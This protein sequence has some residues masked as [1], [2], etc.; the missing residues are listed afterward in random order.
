[1][2]AGP[3]LVS[4]D[5]SLELDSTYSPPA[6]IPSDP[7]LMYY[8]S[9]EMDHMLEPIKVRVV[10]DN[11]DLVT[12]PVTVI[13][14][15]ILST[16]WDQPDNSGDSYT[17]T[18]CQHTKWSSRFGTCRF[19][20]DDCIEMTCN[21]T[22]PTYPLGKVEVETVD[23]VASFE[24]LLHTVYSDTDQRRIRFFADIN[25]TMVNVTTEAFD[26]TRK[27]LAN[28]NYLFSLSLSYS[29]PSFPLSSL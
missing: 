11:G 27:F 8:N 13:A 19:R 21:T 7:A 20:F 10:D 9:P 26:V 29:H 16:N 4:G 17:G 24:R 25:G 6:V 12:Q 3:I 28:S 14:T 5:A 1:M 2:Y 15:T 22:D 18:L 23:G